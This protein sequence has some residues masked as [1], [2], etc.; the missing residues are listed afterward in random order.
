MA[1]WNR[2]GLVR[3]IQTLYEAGTLSGLDDAE[4]LG[5][6]LDRGDGAQAAFEAILAR[7]A[8]MVHDV[9][10]AVAGSDAD[11][12]DAFQ[13]TFLVLACRAAS[14][15]RRGSLASW[16]FGVARRV[17][18]RARANAARRRA[19]ESRAREAAPT[20]YDPTEPDDAVTMLIE[21]VDRLPA[22]YRDPIVLCHLQGLTYEAAARRLGCP[23]GT[24]S[25]RLKRAKLRLRDRLERRGFD[26]AL[27][28][29]TLPGA[30]VPGALATETARIACLVAPA[31]G[32]GVPAS[33]LSLSRGA[34]RT[35]RTQKLVVASAAFL[36]LAG[37]M[38]AW[39]PTAAGEGP[40]PTQEAVEPR[41]AV[42]YQ[43]AGRVVDEETGEPVAGATIQ[44]STSDSGAGGFVE[45]E[46]RSGPDGAYFVT[47][48][49][50]HSQLTRISPPPGYYV[51]GEILGL[52]P[53]AVSDDA[54]VVRKDYVVRR[55]ADWRFRLAWAG[56]GRS[57]ARGSI[58]TGVA[59]AVADGAGEARVALSRSRGEVKGSV[60][61]PGDWTSSPSAF[62]IRWDDQF[63][64]EAVRSVDRLEG[65]GARYRLTDQDGRCATFE[66]V[67]GGRF[68]PR[69]EGGRLVVHVALPDV[70]PA[71]LPETFGTVV[72][73][74]G[75]PVPG[76]LVEVVY[77]WRLG[78]ST[79][80]S[81]TASE[82]CRTRTDAQGRYR[83]DCIPETS[84]GS[85]PHALELSISGEGFVAVDTEPLDVRRDAALEFP[86]VVLAPGGSVVGTVVDVDGKP[87]GG[88]VVEDV[89]AS[90]LRPHFTRT[91]AS[92]RFRLDGLP[93][94]R[95]FLAARYGN[96]MSESGVSHE[97]LR[98]DPRPVTIR[99]VPIPEFPDPG[100]GPRGEVL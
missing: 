83:F 87:L 19:H 77:V 57:A 36:V 16:L 78:G 60:E 100:P 89:Q 85:A 14:V 62:L 49:L 47:L 56:D 18:V 17:A 12:E 58:Y 82:H 2:E 84:G 44:V 26:P 55:G 43:M 64:P 74:S 40:D 25:I 91:D 79:H 68:D 63:R 96:L 45:K 31:L 42:K 4:L 34:L 23:L 67:A 66:D 29:V 53:F 11:A 5:R 75:G 28:S 48:P 51:P 35:M 52:R 76:A 94:G 1:G 37:G 69:L 21:E 22:R 39:K 50:G 71:V 15:R 92:G 30:A 65:E 81:M 61:G 13:A 98:E 6:F 8:A 80:R 20:A 10:R 73:R 93:E 38:W 99:L 9:C 70:Q 46:G 86:A 32:A 97:A 33:V 88:A 27:G 72:D 90:G 59:H 95:V 54:P 41:P 3:S 7:H 24:L